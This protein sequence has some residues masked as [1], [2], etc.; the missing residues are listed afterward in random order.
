MSLEP[1]HLCDGGVSVVLTPS[2]RGEPSI[3][4]WG[5]ELG[6]LEPADLAGLSELRRPGIPQSALDEPRSLPVLPTTPSG[7]TGTPAVEGWR[8]G[9]GGPSPAWTDWTLSRQG[10]LVELRGR[11]ADAGLL[12]ELELELTATGVLRMRTTVTNTGPG[13]F[14]VSAVRNVLPVSAEAT[15]LLD[16]TG[17]WCRERSPQRTRWNHGTWVR[18]GRHGR[19]GHDATLLMVAGT[20][21]FSFASGSVWATHVAWSGDHASYAER[22]P[23]GEAVLGGGELLSPGEIVL[24][25]G[26]AYTTPWLLAVF[27]ADGLDGVSRRLHPWV[28]AGAPHPGSPRPVVLNTWEATY[29]DHVPD[30]LIRLADAAA[31][32]GVERFVLDDGWFTGRRNDR[33]GLGD[34]TVD[35]ERYPEGLHPLVEHVLGRGMQFGLW[36]EPE[37]VNADSDLA[38]AHPE[39]L[40]RGR[41]RLPGEW[42][43]QQVLDLQHP[44][45]YAEVRDALLALLREYPVSFLKWDHNRDLVD[46]LHD[47]RSAV[48]GQTLAVYGLLDELRAAHPGLEI[49]TCASGGGR[50]DLEMLTRTDRVWAS[51][52]SDPVERQHIQRWTGL[53]VPP[54]MIGCHVASPVSHTT[55]RTHRLR[56]RAA[57][58]LL[59]HFGIEWDLTTLTAEESVELAAWVAVHKDLRALVGVGTVVH[60]EHPDPAVLVTGVVSPDRDR[61]VFVVATV[62]STLTQAPTPVALTGLDPQTTYVVGPLGPPAGQ[63]L[64]DLG[65]TWLDK[66]PVEVAGAVLMRS[67]LQLPATPPESA[68]VIEVVARDVAAPT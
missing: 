16:L 39:W 29:F 15:E 46:T 35:S 3:T 12:A 57:T 8:P 53:L 25:E 21:G 22:T 49:E 64:I 36:V 19:T 14:M 17:R 43:H 51:D 7:Y 48:H 5:A 2:S 67:G 59:G 60:P 33:S 27:A 30:R 66:G 24:A 32:L 37:M 65:A 47:G 13:D 26:A 56:F 63:P 1:L 9:R 55:G 68:Y 50:V 52:T 44:A 42:R 6:P 34:W 28:R 40:L 54:E 45:A 18:Q 41:A 61:A 31:D 58:A 4:Y 38:R 23:E 20:P 11:D 62:A 10:G